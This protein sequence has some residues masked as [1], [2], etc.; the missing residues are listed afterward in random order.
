[1][2]ALVACGVLAVP[3]LGAGGD[4]GFPGPATGPVQGEL[5]MSKPQSKLWFTSR[6]W[7]ADMLDSASKH[8]H[9][10]RL[11]RSTET[12]VDSGVEADPL[13][14]TRAD[15]LWDA[16][17]GKLYI[18]SHKLSAAAETTHQ[19]DIPDPSPSTRPPEL[20]RYSYD[21]AADRYVPDPGFP[22]KIGAFDVE[23]LVIAK[24]STGRLWATWTSGDRVWVNHTSGAD[25]DWGTPYVIPGPGPGP[26]LTPDDISSVIAFGG[27]AIGVLSSRQVDG[28]FYRAGHRAGAGAGRWSV[29]RVPCSEFSDD[30]INLEADAVGRV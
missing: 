20:W 23:A 3:A 28:D 30:H 15:V 8:Y 29:S 19:P 7:W 12:W 27:D 22:V 1:V 10:F 6:G 17:A 2:A 13:A 26:T 5:T 16:A 25:T 11:D 24:D 14:S 21:A 18:A 9:F 4:I